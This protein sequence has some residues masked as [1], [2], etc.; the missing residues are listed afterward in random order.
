MCASAYFLTAPIV[1]RFSLSKLLTISLR[2]G[3]VMVGMVMSR[4]SQRLTRVLSF[5]GSNE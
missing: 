5:S 1:R 4:T 2:R 3:R